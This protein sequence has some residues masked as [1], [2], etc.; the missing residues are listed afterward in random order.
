MTDIFMA[1]LRSVAGGGKRAPA[2]T[3]WYLFFPVSEGVRQGLVQGEAGRPSGV[4]VQARDVHGGGGQVDGP[5]EVGPLTEIHVHPC[6]GDEA[7]ED[8]AHGPGAAGGDVV[9]LTLFALFHEK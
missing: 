1:N 6:E 9:S 3:S 8:V 4:A 2:V 5:D 7:V